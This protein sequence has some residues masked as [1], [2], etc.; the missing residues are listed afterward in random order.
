MPMEHAPCQI[1]PASTDDPLAGLR[2][3]LVGILERTSVD[4]QGRRVFHIV[5]HKCEYVD[6]MKPVWTR[7][8][9]MRA[10]CRA[11]I[12]NGLKAAIKAGQLP[13]GLNVQRKAEGLHCLI[14]GLISNWVMDPAAIPAANEAERL[15]DV[16]IEGLRHAPVKALS[17]RP[18]AV[19]R[20]PATPVRSKAA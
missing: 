3:M 9:E 1:D 15:I 12:E 20:K 19:R 16:F 17:S 8:S 4:A 6:E 14:D 13:R 18:A 5:F 10:G 7:F 11:R 2:A